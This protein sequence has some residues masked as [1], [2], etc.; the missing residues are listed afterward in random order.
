M[1]RMKLIQ[2]ATGWYDLDYQE[3]FS[4]RL[5]KQWNVFVDAWRLACKGVS[6]YSKVECH[7]GR[8]LSLSR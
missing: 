5:S 4:P 3:L 7:V 1:S 6:E 8:G 2:R